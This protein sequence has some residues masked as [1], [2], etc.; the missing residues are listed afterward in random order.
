MDATYS[1]RGHLSAGRLWASWALYLGL[2]LA[3]LSAASAS[4]AGLSAIVG[5][6]TW[7]TA[8]LAFISVT[9]QAV[10]AFLKPADR[11]KEHN[12]KG[13]QYLSLR[14]ASRFFRDVDLRVSDVPAQQL[15]DRLRELRDRYNALNESEPQ[16]PGWAYAEA[17]AGIARGESDYES[18]PLWG[19]SN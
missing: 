5:A 12:A 18:D 16:I 2:P 15:V 4:G 14:N 11:A 1:G 8:S 19:A 6:G 3:I 13:N 10:N 9:L 7:W 17:K